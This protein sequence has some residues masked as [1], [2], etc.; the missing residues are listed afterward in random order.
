MRIGFHLTPPFSRHKYQASGSGQM[1]DEIVGPGVSH[2]RSAVYH[3]RGL[4]PARPMG[5]Q[6]RSVVRMVLFE[7][8]L[9]VSILYCWHRT[10]GSKDGGGCIHAYTTRRDTDSRVRVGGLE[11]STCTHSLLSP[12]SRGHGH[13][14]FGLRTFGLCPVPSARFL[15]PG[16]IPHGVHHQ[17]CK[18]IS[19]VFQLNTRNTTNR[20]FLVASEAI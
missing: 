19:C 17:P 20:Q 4:A 10:G 8:G 11:T 12:V 14:I 5:G 2:R 18:P 3:L 7:I 6:L 16:I 13:E 9:K 15:L 1:M